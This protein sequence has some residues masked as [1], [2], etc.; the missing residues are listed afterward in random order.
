MFENIVQMKEKN[1]NIDIKELREKCALDRRL[2]YINSTFQNYAERVNNCIATE[3]PAQMLNIIKNE[4]DEDLVGYKDKLDGMVAILSN[5][6]NNKS[7][8]KIMDDVHSELKLLSS[9]V[10]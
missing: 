3:L 8:P 10:N 1:P 2:Q 4:V 9:K 5:V 6:G 7:T